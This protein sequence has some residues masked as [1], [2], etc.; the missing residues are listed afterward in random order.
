M[1]VLFHWLRIEQAGAE[2]GQ[3]QPQMGL[4]YD[5]EVAD[6]LL[7]GNGIFIVYFVGLEIFLVSTH[8]DNKC[9][10]GHR[11]LRVCVVKNPV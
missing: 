3:T 7:C 2:L 4:N 11:K 6:F 8:G 5:L 9:G 10:S 1:Y